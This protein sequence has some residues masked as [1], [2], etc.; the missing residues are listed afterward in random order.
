M[1]KDRINNNEP[2]DQSST[3]RCIFLHLI[4]GLIAVVIYIVTAPYFIKNELPSFFA[5]FI[6]L[7]VSFIMILIYLFFKSFR[8]TGKFAL[9]NIIYNREKLKLRE[10][11][12]YI[13]IFIVWSLIAGG[14]FTQLNNTFISKVFSWLPDWFW[15]TKQFEDLNALSLP[16]LFTLFFT[17]TIGNALI[18]PIVEEIYFRGYLLPRMN[19]AGK[20][21]P[22]INVLLFSI[23]HFF[24]PE[25]NLARLF[26]LSPMVYVVWKKKNIYLMIITH[27]IIN[28]VPS[29]LV[30]ATILEKM[31]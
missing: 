18:G 5:L 2:V 6:G 23:Y 4:P 1:N 13:P 8:A 10:Y 11:L 24:S 25:Q 21:A 7:M 14:I 28:I 26:I 3:I 29:I 31:T 12:T 20:W 22:F 15:W 9:S 16:V 17:L 27:C 19:R 30:A